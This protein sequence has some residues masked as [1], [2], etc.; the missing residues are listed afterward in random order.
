MYKNNGFVLIEVLTTIL[1]FQI[2]LMSLIEINRTTFRIKIYSK[3]INIAVG[4]AE[5]QFTECSNSKYKDIS[6]KKGHFSRQNGFLWKCF[7]RDISNDNNL[8]KMNKLKKYS[9]NSYERTIFLS[10]SKIIMIVLKKSI[11]NLAITIFWKKYYVTFNT[12]FNQK[13]S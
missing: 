13:I 4:L 12:Y 7:Y 2:I 3:N 5:N 1:L 10:L 9:K 11:K 6:I 8:Y